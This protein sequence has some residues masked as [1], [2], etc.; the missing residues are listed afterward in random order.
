LTVR[1]SKPVAAID[2]A[3]WDK[4]V[5]EFAQ[6]KESRGERRALL[7]SGNANDRAQQEFAK[8][9]MKLCGGMRP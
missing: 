1:R 6:R 4:P 2:Y 3:Y 9:G 8:A 7:T 5:A